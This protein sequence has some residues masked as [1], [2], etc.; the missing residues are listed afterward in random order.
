MVN[1]NRPGPPGYG[2]RPLPWHHAS[3]GELVLGLNLEKAPSGW[4]PKLKA[5]DDD[6]DDDEEEEE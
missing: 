2:C 5:D 1:R 4:I 3:N 6:D